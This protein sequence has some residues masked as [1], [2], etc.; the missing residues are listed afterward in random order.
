MSTDTA[1]SI[2]DLLARLERLP[3]DRSLAPL[4]PLV[5]RRIA[6]QSP[7]QSASWGWRASIVAVALAFG[8]LSGSAVA[9]RQPSELALFS[10]H[11]A[12]APS[13]LLGLSK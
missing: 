8:A 2:D 6:A 12:L 11:A 7:G 4:E 5:W 13:T 3:P 1:A 10:T 9:A